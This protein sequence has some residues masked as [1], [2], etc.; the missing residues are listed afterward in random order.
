MLRSARL[1][2]AWLALHELALHALALHVSA[3]GCRGYHGIFLASL[4]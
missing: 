3:V 1:A 2:L 4:I